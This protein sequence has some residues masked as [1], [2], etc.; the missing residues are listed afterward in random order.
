MTPPLTPHGPGFRFLDSIVIDGDSA[1]G[2]WKPAADLWFF[3]DHFPGD[4]LVPAAIM[5]EF[6]AQSA[7]AFWMRSTGGTGPLFVAG[8]DNTAICG[9][10]RPG[11]ELACRISLEREL[12]PLA[13]FLFE[14]TG[15]GGDVA[16]GRVTLS[17]R[18]GGS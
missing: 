14:I 16:R 1:T 4:P 9:S 8:V 3:K 13:V 2:H 6:A 17:R 15:P 10:A 5:V 11:Q 12:G 7:G 18:L